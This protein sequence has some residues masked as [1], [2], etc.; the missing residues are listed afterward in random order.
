MSDV[1]STEGDHEHN[2]DDDRYKQ[3]ALSKLRFNAS[4]SSL[5]MQQVIILHHDVREFNGKISRQG[6]QINMEAAIEQIER[7]EQSYQSYLT[8]SHVVNGSDGMVDNIWIMLEKTQMLMEDTQNIINIILNHISQ[9][10]SRRSTRQSSSP[11]TYTHLP[12]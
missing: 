7:Q 6:I 1:H 8:L 10:T 3:A 9:S 12:R 5:L 4:Q 11:S 2:R